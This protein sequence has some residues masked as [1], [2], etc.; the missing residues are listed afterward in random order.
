MRR[1]IPFAL[2]LALVSLG[3]CAWFQK[4]PTIDAQQLAYQHV[5]KAADVVN[6]AG[7]VTASAQ[8]MEIALYQS[9][10]IP[11]ALHLT[12]Q[13]G[14]L[15]LGLDV[16][17]GLTVLRDLTQTPMQQQAAVTQIEASMTTFIN[18]LSSL[19]ADAK[20]KIT[21]VMN[22][23]LLIVQGAFLLI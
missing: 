18:S 20:T 2:V 9:G 1:L 10:A 12:I 3:G 7:L 5:K 22:A 14:F 6:A 15:T 16:Q 13:Q 19:N 23:A 8:Q 4:A 11:R 21:T 17:K